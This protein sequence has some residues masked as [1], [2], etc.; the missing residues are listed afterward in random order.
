MYHIFNFYSMY[1]KINE[2]DYFRI[3][4]NKNAFFSHFE[5]IVFENHS[6]SN[7]IQKPI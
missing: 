7:N 4:I 5:T 3:T 6:L 2:T 1:L